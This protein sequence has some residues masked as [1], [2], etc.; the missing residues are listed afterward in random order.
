MFHDD[1]EKDGRL[2]IVNNKTGRKVV[3]FNL[4][5]VL[6][7]LRTSDEL[8]AYSE[9]E[10]LD[11]GYDYQITVFLRGGDLQYINISISVLGWTKH[12]QFNEL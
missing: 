6:S 5:D 8:H 1:A 3:D 10:F 12:I 9:Q 7:R 4:P 2:Y 11:R